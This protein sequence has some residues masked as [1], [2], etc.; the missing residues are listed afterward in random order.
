MKKGNY[1]YDEEEFQKQATKFVKRTLAPQINIIGKAKTF[2]G[3]NGTRTVF[4][5]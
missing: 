1:Y 4:W 2:T 3:A 5:W